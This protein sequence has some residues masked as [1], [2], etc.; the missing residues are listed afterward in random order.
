VTIVSNHQK[1]G[2][3]SELRAVSESDMGSS[4]G[5]VFILCPY[6]DWGEG[7]WVPTQLSR[8]GSWE[9]KLLYVYK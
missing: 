2:E 9:G 5:F 1:S 8:I 4:I 3:G 7:S 6:R